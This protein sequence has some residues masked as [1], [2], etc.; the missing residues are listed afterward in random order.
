MIF[1]KNTDLG[2]LLDPVQD[3]LLYDKIYYFILTRNW[4]RSQELE[5]KLQI[6]A[7][8]LALAKSFGS[9]R[10][11]LCNTGAFYMQT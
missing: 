1:G 4:S 2:P 6:P 5:P 7:P 3:E 11:W 9:L 10:L 8:A